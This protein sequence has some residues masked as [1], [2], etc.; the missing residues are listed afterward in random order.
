MVKHYVSRVCSMFIWFILLAAIVYKVPVY[1]Q[2]DVQLAV[3]PAFA[4]NYVP[5]TW[6][7][8]Q[9]SLNNNGSAFAA[10]V[11]AAFPN[12]TDRYTL[13]V[14]LPRN[15]QKVVTLYVAMEQ[16]S[17]QLEV[18]VEHN[19][20]PVAQQ[21][22]Q[23]R[24]RVDERLMGLVGEPPPTLILPRRQDIQRFPF[25]TFDL[26]LTAIPDQAYGLGSLTLLL[27]AD[28]PTVALQPAQQQA[29]LGW[30]AMGGHLVL[31]GGPGAQRTV[32]GLPEELRPAAIGETFNLDGKFLGAFA[33]TTGIETLPGVKLQPLEGSEASGPA[34]APLWVQRTFE[35]GRITQLAFNPEIAAIRT[36]PTAPAFW[37]RLLQPAFL[38]A[39]SFG[40]EM[41]PLRSQEQLLTSAVG[42]LPALNL[43]RFTEL[44]LGL[45]LYTLFIGPGI[46]LVLRR[47]DRQAWGWVVLPVAALVCTGLA[48]GLAFMLR[49]DQRI[50]SQVSLIE[51]IG[52][53]QALARTLVGILAPQDSQFAVQVPRNALVRP[54]RS[55]SS[56]FGSVGGAPGD[57]A[58]QTHVSEISTRRWE[59]QGVIAEQQIVFPAIDAQ[60]IL[61]HDT[62]QA[63]VHNT[64][65]QNLRD[66]VI[67]YAEQVAYIGD[68]APGQQETVPWPG[69]DDN[70]VEQPT[71]GVALSYLVL[72][73]QLDA[74]RKPGA[75]PDRR[76]LLREM[77][78]NAAV[79]RGTGVPEEGP[80]VL[81]W[82]T[83][84][85][86]PVT[87]EASG[88][89]LQQTTLMV[90]RPHLRGSGVVSLPPGWL[91]P[92]ASVDQRAT[93]FSGSNQRGL[94]TQ[95]APITITL[96]LPSDLAAVRTT[97]LSL[98][99]R[100]ERTWPNTGVTTELFDWQQQ[101]W[102]DFDYDGPGDFLVSAPEPYLQDGTVRLRLGGRIDEGGCLF[103]QAQLVGILL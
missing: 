101:R 6:L 33:E 59:V 89:A 3:T 73:T 31:A 103:V 58:Q 92:D 12:S 84:T 15:A 25:V 95:P 97:A 49:A 55:T 78:I 34:A 64:T 7:P 32:A 85:P 91:R 74:G 48:F 13:A 43:P 29:L 11:T 50:V 67:A 23:V 81:A 87:V 21:E 46:A 52:P 68:L 61:E 38:S 36:W 60:I 83:H 79:A 14:E 22:V 8:L 27:L 94:S 65:D 24:P 44:F 2:P 72:G 102:I 5:G 1:A 80:L 18:T 70:Q 62:I 90:A 57:Y 35:N 100:S 37:D 54:L 16:S 9:I 10:L 42:N 69:M 30:V 28:V 40:L 51:Q 26:S 47:N 98:T 86:L 77:L 99:L 63:R 88:A 19:G 75:V 4:G 56:L 53:D 17:Q 82:L 20:A 39:G 93:C 41:S 76:V 66:V 45:A 96:R 71:P